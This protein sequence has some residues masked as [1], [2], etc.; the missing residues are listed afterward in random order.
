VGFKEKSEEQGGPI[1]SGKKKKTLGKVS[2]GGFGKVFEVR[3]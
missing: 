2:K 1:N 3:D